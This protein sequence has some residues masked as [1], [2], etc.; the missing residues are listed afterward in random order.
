MNTSTPKPHTDNPSRP[1]RLLL[2]M[3][4]LCVVSGMAC[5]LGFRLAGSSVQADGVLKEPFYLLGIGWG[6]VIAAF[7]S[8]VAAWIAHRVAERRAR[9]IS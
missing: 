6:L 2:R 7:A 8:F 5:M 9:S 4:V 3:A 1:V